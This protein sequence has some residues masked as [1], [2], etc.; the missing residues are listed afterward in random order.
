[1]SD[2]ANER[3]RLF[4]EKEEALASDEA[5]HIHNGKKSVVKDTTSVKDF[6]PDQIRSYQ[7]QGLKF[8]VECQL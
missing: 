2:Q 3:Y 5:Q 8:V 6:G 1:M 4:T 7:E